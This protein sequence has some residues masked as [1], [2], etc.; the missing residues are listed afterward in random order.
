M[1]IKQI[2]EYDYNYAEY[3]VTDGK[4]DIVC[5]CLSVPLENNNEP[6]IGMK[7]DS[8]YAF[9]YNDSIILKVSNTNKC[10]IQKDTKNYFKYNLC[11]I[12]VD[13]KKSIIKVFD[14]VIDLSNDYPNGF[15]T[16]IKDGDYVEFD[17]DRIDCI[18]A[19]N[20]NE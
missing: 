19:K 20:I 15:D 7:V 17:V 5:M 14:F 2:L 3:I 8:L 10:N 1:E 9:S 6:K 18:L 13:S 4:Y 12:V 16:L 11:E